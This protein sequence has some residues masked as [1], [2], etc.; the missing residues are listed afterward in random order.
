MPSRWVDDGVGN[1][2]RW[3]PTSDTRWRQARRAPER[4]GRQHQVFREHGKEPFCRNPW[5]RFCP[6]AKAVR[7]IACHRGGP[8]AMEEERISSLKDQV[9]ILCPLCMSLSSNLLCPRKCHARQNRFLTIRETEWYVRACRHGATPCTTTAIPRCA[10]RR[11][12]A[13]G[14]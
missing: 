1:I 8:L 2:H 3:Q 10:T 12:R 6:C 9:G 4:Q 11:R 5:R 7:P 13:R 14:T